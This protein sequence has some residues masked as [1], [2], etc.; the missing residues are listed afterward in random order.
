ME[1]KSFL[2]TSSC[3]YKHIIPCM[4]FYEVTY[5]TTIGSTVSVESIWNES[6]SPSCGLIRRRRYNVRT[7]VLAYPSRSTIHSPRPYAKIS[8]LMLKSTFSFTLLSFKFESRPV[9]TSLFNNVERSAISEFHENAPDLELYFRTE[10]SCWNDSKYL[11]T[12]VYQWNFV[13]NES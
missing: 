9:S 11:E 1:L 5:V 6:D 7:G 3:I 4:P 2:Q 8:H 13:E 10:D 12:V